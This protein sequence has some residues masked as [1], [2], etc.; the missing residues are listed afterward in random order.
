VQSHVIRAA[1]TLLRVNFFHKGSPEQGYDNRVGH[2]A[3][4]SPELMLPKQDL[5]TVTQPLPRPVNVRPF[6]CE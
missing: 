5:A 2:R 6:R 3:G 4:L 1:V